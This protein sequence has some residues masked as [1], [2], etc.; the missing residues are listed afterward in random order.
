M[1]ITVKQSER[2][3]APAGLHPARLVQILY[4][5]IQKNEK[6]NKKEARIRLVWELI[7]V[8]FENAEGEELNHMVG[9]EYSAK[10]SGKSFL[11]KAVEAMLGKALEN[12]SE[13][14]FEGLLDSQCQIQVSEGTN[15]KKEPIA[16]VDAVLP[17]AKDP[18]TN[19]PLKYDR[20][21]RDMIYFTMEVDEDG[22]VTLDEGVLENL[23]EWIVNI[24]LASEEYVAYQ[25]QQA[26]AFAEAQKTKKAPAT[27]PA[28]AK[29]AAKA[30]PAKKA[31]AK[32]K[33]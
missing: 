6:F 23:P 2:K 31:V 32:A 26:A 13:F 8:T 7:G 3:V 4:L 14:E 11:R 28:P 30:A 19:K 1:K 22:A 12:D 24:I 27:K 16:L 20:A 21:Q 29:T 25:E 17:V 5:G 33:K 10:L 9:K 15:S 18:K